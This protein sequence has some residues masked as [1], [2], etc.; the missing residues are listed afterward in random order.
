[1]YFDLFYSR[2]LCSFCLETHLLFSDSLYVNFSGLTKRMCGFQRIFWDFQTGY[3][4]II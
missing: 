3:A 2:E 1:M 4:A